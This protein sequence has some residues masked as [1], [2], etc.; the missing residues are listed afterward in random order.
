MLLL[1]TTVSVPYAAMLTQATYDGATHADI[2]NIQRE[3]LRACVRFGCI[4]RK[5]F[6]RL[7]SLISQC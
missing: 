3:T 4:V 1:G 5:A 6:G 7:M 2:C